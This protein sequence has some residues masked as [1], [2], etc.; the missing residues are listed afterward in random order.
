MASQAA[1]TSSAAIRG[2][3]GHPLIDWDSHIIEY[4]PVLSVFIEV[5]QILINGS[6]VCSLMR[7][8]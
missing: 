8:L 3:L 5:L 2:K 6:F 4:T 1:P 7:I